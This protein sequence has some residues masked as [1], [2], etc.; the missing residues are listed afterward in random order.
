MEFPPELVKEIQARLDQAK[1]LNPGAESPY[2]KAVMVDGSI[3]YG[4]FVSPDGDIFMETYDLGTDDPPVYDR[5]R[6]AQIA[7]LVLGSRTMPKLAEML[8][9][10]PPEAPTCAKCNGTGWL[11]Q[12]LRQTFGKDWKGFLCDKCSGLGWLEVS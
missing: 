11:H 1:E 3:G 7:V 2:G 5:S 9:K 12:E 8:P 4:C 6:L 10:R